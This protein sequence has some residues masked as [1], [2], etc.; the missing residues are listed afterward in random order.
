MRD[1]QNETDY[2]NL[3]IDRVGIRDISWPIAVPDRDSGTQE[4]IANVS[5]SVSLPRDYRGTHMSRFV[6]VLS[7]QEKRVTFHNMEGLLE[8]LR[9][10]LSAKDA[11]AVFDFPYFITKS[12]PV[13]GAKG[14]VRCDV[15]FDASLVDDEFDL[16]TT[17]TAPIQT[18]CPCSKEI[19]DF[20]AHNQR[21]HA[22]MEVRLS[23]FVWLEEFVKMADDCA[24][25]PIY[26]LLKREDEKFVTE[27]AYMHPKFVE[28]TVRDLALAMRAEPRVLWYRVSVASHESI[29]NH[30]AFAVI[31]GDKRNG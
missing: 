25:A 31:V 20:G 4:T 2:R 19:S 29:H 7:S 1:V 12:A 27:R 9:A 5:L 18:L 24:S 16:V 14:R 15:R 13:S 17:V 6:E 8:T 23:G 3:E 11:H 28:D 10:R 26:S 30:D 22:V 21:A